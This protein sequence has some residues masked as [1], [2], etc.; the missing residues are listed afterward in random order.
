MWRAEQGI[1]WIEQVRLWCGLSKR[2]LSTVNSQLI[3]VS[4]AVD[5]V[6][7]LSG[8]YPLGGI[9]ETFHDW[10]E[11]PLLSARARMS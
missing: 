1:R 8:S 11:I 10:H 9:M 7:V 5:V 6:L 2:T 3:S 4:V